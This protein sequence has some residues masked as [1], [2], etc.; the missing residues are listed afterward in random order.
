M[1]DGLRMV[2]LAPNFEF[3]ASSSHCERAEVTTKRKKNRKRA[4]A[5]SATTTLCSKW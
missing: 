2:C 3:A 1:I 5:R 4:V